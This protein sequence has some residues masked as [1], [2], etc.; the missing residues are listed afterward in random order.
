MFDPV[1]QLQKNVTSAEKAIEKWKKE[2]PGKKNVPQF[3]LTQLSTAEA[4]LDELE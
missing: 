1:K 2:N 3:L 4:K